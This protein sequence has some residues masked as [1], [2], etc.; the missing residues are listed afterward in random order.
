ML[1]HNQGPFSRALAKS[2]SCVRASRPNF[3]LRDFFCED[4]PLSRMLSMCEMTRD[5]S[6]LQLVGMPASTGTKYCHCGN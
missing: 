5:T 4:V 1:C 2:S 6:A 3:F